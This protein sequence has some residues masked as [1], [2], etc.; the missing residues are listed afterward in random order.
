MKLGYIRVN[1]KNDFAIDVQKSELILNGATK[2]YID[3]GSDK[4][5]TRTGLKEL[6]KQAK[7][8]DT[9]VVTSFD[10]LARRFEKRISIIKK[11]MKK[12]VYLEITRADFK[13]HISLL[14]YYFVEM[15]ESFK[16]QQ[17]NINNY[18]EEIEHI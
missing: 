10:R 3:I 9:I 18:T 6:L 11:F 4:I 15:Y 13:G 14:Y 16:I 2:I 12:D 1:N 5:T 17:K 7:K 8:G